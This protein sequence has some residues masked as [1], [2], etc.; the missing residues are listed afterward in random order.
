MSTNQ[1]LARSL[2]L[3][4]SNSDDVLMEAAHQSVVGFRFKRHGESF[5]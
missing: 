4:E 1:S 3:D 5:V 2:V